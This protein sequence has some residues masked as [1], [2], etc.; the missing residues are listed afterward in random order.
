MKYIHRYIHMDKVI[1]GGHFT[2]EYTADLM[3]T[4]LRYYDRKLVWIR[5]EGEEWVQSF[6]HSDPDK[7][8]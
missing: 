8:I 6:V 1:Y 5:P 4:V 2:I 7:N 3:A